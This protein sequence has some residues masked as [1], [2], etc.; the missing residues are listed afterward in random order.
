[1]YDIIA[2]YFARV[3]SENP[4]FFFTPMLYSVICYF[5]VGL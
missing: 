1:M 3:V 2:Y 5:G 4:L